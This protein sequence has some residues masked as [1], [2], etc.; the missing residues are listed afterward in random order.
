MSTSVAQQPDLGSQVLAKTHYGSRLKDALIRDREV[1]EQKLGAQR[2]LGRFNDEEVTVFEANVKEARL[3]YEQQLE[4]RRHAEERQ[5]EA[6]A[7]ILASEARKKDLIGLASRIQA[8]KIQVMNQNQARERELDFRA[9]TKQ[10]REAF[11]QRVKVIEQAQAAERQEL[12]D[13][14]ERIAR[15]LKI[16][17]A[18][19]MREMSEKDIA[20][21]KTEY[22][23]EYE[24]LK[25][26]Q[27][28]EAEQLRELQLLKVRH[29]SEQMDLELLSSAEIEEMIGEH[30]DREDLYLARKYIEKAAESTKLDRQQAQL[31]AL[32]LKEEQKLVQ[33]QLL[34]SQVRQRK[35][36]ER[37]QKSSARL[38]ERAALDDAM[39]TMGEAI[40]GVKHRAS[41]FDG[42]EMQSSAIESSDMDPSEASSNVGDVEAAT[43]GEG[44]T[45]AE[46][47]EKRRKQRTAGDAATE[48]KE[49]FAKGMQR[50]RALDID[51][52]KGLDQLRQQHKD[53][54]HQ[55]IR[56]SKRKQTQLLKDQEDE[57][58][59]IRTEHA[60]DM[61]ELCELILQSQEL[62]RAQRQVDFQGKTDTSSSIVENIMPAEFMQAIREGSRPAPVTYE[63]A[64]VVRT[65]I[66]DYNSLKPAQSVTLLQRMYGAFEEVLKEF[67]GAVKVASVGDMYEICVGLTHKNAD[68]NAPDVAATALD[69]ATRLASSFSALYVSDL[70]IPAGKVSLKIGVDRGVVKAGLLGSRVPQFVVHGVPVERAKQ[71]SQAAEPGHILLA[72]DLKDRMDQRYKFEKFGNG[73]LFRLVPPSH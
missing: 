64:V 36:L 71:L 48:L 25:M 11:T 45:Q 43:G 38:R 67:P 13:A 3:L 46:D 17:H 62:Q 26:R 40:N 10:K 56:E 15:N 54:V 22:Q 9:A 66:A 57:V 20:K 60:Q 72:K 42:S 50:L 21:K 53:Q 23:L 29:M 6:A 5:R 12:V 16:I 14:Q 63:N 18:L 28:K 44:S 70:N 47:M 55:R 69:L 52:K 7:D 39:S 68:D 34:H 31:K 37:T 58:R 33:G 49:A 2:K 8:F 51:Q 59:S 27:Q 32:Q 1:K 41:E 35:M 65:A 19:E 4:E 30:K 61:Q 24:Q 73:D